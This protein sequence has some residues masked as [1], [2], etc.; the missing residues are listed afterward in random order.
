[1]IFQGTD[2]SGEPSNFLI[3]LGSSECY[4]KVQDLD[5]WFFPLVNVGLFDFKVDSLNP[6]CPTHDLYPAQVRLEVV[7]NTSCFLQE[8]LQSEIHTNFISNTVQHLPA[9]SY[10]RETEVDKGLAEMFLISMFI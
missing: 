6:V 3:S 4:F 9:F 2:L 10:N 1:M 7:K 5:L 8:S